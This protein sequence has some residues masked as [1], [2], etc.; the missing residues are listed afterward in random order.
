MLASRPMPASSQCLRRANAC[1]EPMLASSQCLH[2]ANACVEPMLALTSSGELSC[3]IGV[4]SFWPSTCMHPI[5]SLAGALE[6]HVHVKAVDVSDEI[7]VDQAAVSQVLT[8]VSH[9]Q[10]SHTGLTH[11]AHTQDA[12]TRLTHQP[13]TQV[14]HKSHAANCVPFGHNPLTLRMDQAPPFLSA[15]CLLTSS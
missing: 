12:H 6:S 13:H 5:V 1:V 10:V 4:D 7:Q 15:P 9:A 2:R 3:P 14:S 11:K 8:Q